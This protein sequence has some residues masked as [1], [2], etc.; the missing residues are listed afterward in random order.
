MYINL[1]NTKMDNRQQNNTNINPGNLDITFSGVLNSLFYLGTILVIGYY[2]WNWWRNTQRLQKESLL[3][4]QGITQTKEGFSGDE[5]DSLALEKPAA[6]QPKVKCPGTQSVS[7]A[8]GIWD[9]SDDGHILFEEQPRKW[10]DTKL[11]QNRYTPG[12]NQALDELK[13]KY[14]Q[15]LTQTTKEMLPALQESGLVEYLK[16]M[17]DL[18]QQISANSQIAQLKGMMLAQTELLPRIREM[19]ITIN[20]LSNPATTNPIT[21][22]STPISTNS[23]ANI[24]EPTTTNIDE[25]GNISEMTQYELGT[26]IIRNRQMREYL[27]KQIDSGEISMV[28]SGNTLIIFEYIRTN[29]KI[30][31]DLIK[32]IDKLLAAY[33]TLIP[34]ID[35]IIRERAQYEKEMQEIRE[36]ID[37]L[38]TNTLTNSPSSANSA[39]GQ[40][41]GRSQVPNGV[42][43]SNSTTR[44][45]TSDR[46]P[47]RYYL[48]RRSSHLFQTTKNLDALRAQIKNPPSGITPEE[49]QAKYNWID[50][51]GKDKLSVPD[52]PEIKFALPAGIGR[53]IPDILTDFDNNNANCQ[54]IYEECSTRAN[55]PGFALPNWET[56]DYYN[57]LDRLPDAKQASQG[58][59][60]VI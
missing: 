42:L 59:T 25:L 41:G 57:Y 1:Q 47:Q 22:L 35:N 39:N 46:W 56:S 11:T 24:S 7:L 13:T 32:L 18:D 2:L 38:P 15:L 33:K 40:D 5:T 54:R 34:F 55:T 37:I 23:L 27:E 8:Q 19:I 17:E 31:T 43:D 14:H 49:Y 52:D 60:P 10:T 4:S 3:K 51:I 20:P 44:S 26:Q 36:L 29:Q 50:R 6:T 58:S 21:N 53:T 28:S 48:N 12:I 45:P 30:A 9:G 16:V